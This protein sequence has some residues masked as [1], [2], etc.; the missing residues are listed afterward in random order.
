ME[1]KIREDASELYIQN[2]T[3]EFGNY[4]GNPKWEIILYELAGKIIEVDCKL[5]H[6]SL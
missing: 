2:N 5:P 4:F 1:I 3:D 6:Y